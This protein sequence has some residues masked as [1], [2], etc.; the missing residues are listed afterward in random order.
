MVKLRKYNIKLKIITALKINFVTS[1]HKSNHHIY[2][3]IAITGELK[4]RSAARA[5]D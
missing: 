3:Y 1:D 2:N 5:P 4:D